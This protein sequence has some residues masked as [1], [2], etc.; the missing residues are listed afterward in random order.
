MFWLTP[1]QAQTIDS[2]TQ[3]S[4]KQPYIRVSKEDLP[5][6]KLLEQQNAQSQQQ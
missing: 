6:K 1:E 2:S 5:K 3:Q 4:K